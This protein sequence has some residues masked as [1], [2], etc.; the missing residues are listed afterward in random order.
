MTWNYKGEADITLGERHAS[1]LPKI[2]T[3][4]IVLAIIVVGILAFI[5]RDY[6]Y[7]Q[8]NNPHIIL[9]QESVTI[10]YQGKFNAL[11][12][13]D[14]AKT[15]R[16]DKFMEYGSIMTFAPEEDIDYPYFFVY[17]SN[18][19]TSIPGDYKVTYYSHNRIQENEV[20]LSVTV[21]AP[22]DEVA[23]T[24]TLT[25]NE[26]TLY[27]NHEDI[28]DFNLEDY[29]QSVTDDKS[30]DVYLR[31]NLTYEI[32]ESSNIIQLPDIQNLYID[33]SDLDS[34]VTKYSREE[35]EEFIGTYTDL[36]NNTP[37]KSY[38]IEFTTKDESDN[39]SS[40]I[41]NVVVVLDVDMIEEKL[42][43]RIDE[44]NEKQDE[45]IVT[46][47]SG[48]NTNNTQN[49]QNNQKSDKPQSDSDTDV[50]P[51]NRYSFD[52]IDPDKDYSDE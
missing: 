46:K 49:T 52:G 7:D 47:P 48:G 26:V 3:A 5:Q 32:S 2:L 43:A 13:I 42:Q 36:V 28:K 24:I 1:P 21:T 50:T 51:D 30:S 17:D 6:F 12:Y 45:P 14:Q 39:S 40:V 11:D 8:L 4:L 41:L 33:M 35:M 18:V 19:D 20:S 23:P 37:T 22:V 9:T 31:D 44:W 16:Y 27:Y 15:L 38:S 25:T 10:P 34:N 29:I